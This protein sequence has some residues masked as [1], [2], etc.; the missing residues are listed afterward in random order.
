M[1]AQ[2]QVSSSS[3]ET[4]LADQ[5]DLK[6][7]SVRVDEVV[8]MDYRLDGRFHG[9]KGREAR[10]VLEECNWQ[11]VSFGDRF[12]KEAFYLG[13]L[14]RIYV[15]KDT[16]IPFLLPSQIT[17]LHPKA[18]KF[19]SQKTKIDFEAAKAKRGQ[20]LLT[21]SGTIGVVSY[22]SETLRNQ[23][24]SDDVIRIVAGCA[25]GYVYAYFK[26]EIGRTLIQ[27]NEYGAVVKHVEP[28]H[29]NDIPIPDPPWAL[30]K[31]IHDLIEDSF[32]LRDE[33]NALIDEAQHLLQAALELPDIESLKSG[34][35]KFETSAD[36]WN[37]STPVSQLNDRIDG[38]YHTPIVQ[39]IHEHLLKHAREVTSVG[40]NVIVK[41][42]VL[43]GRFK[44]HYVDEE[45][46]AVFFGGKQLY[47]LDPENKK[48]LSRKVH[49][50]LIRQELRI[51]TNTILIT[52]S[53]T[54]GKVAIVPEHW[55][56][57]VPNQHVMRVVPASDR[58]AGYL[59]AWLSSDFAFP[60]I[61]RQ[62]YAA[63]IDEIDASH[64]ASICVPLLHDTLVQQRINEMVLEA[65]GKRTRAYQL[66]QKA[67]KTLDDEVIY[68]RLQD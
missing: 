2:L 5:P 19:I 25:P 43:P 64:V 47:Q 23:T 50:E 37:F 4:R 46:G 65:N 44:R 58:I 14:K 61:T 33:S 31:K 55:S 27:T 62:A 35:P 7:V 60:L 48:Y 10:R 29:L 26:S 30:K 52:C 54:I 1:V 32:R 36:F 39:T 11:T 38:S 18:T 59:Y 16:G 68:S 24:I 22:V 57:W 12:L 51:H 41:S 17:D 40:D 63:V 49:D 34:A 21:R 67:L 9:S 53:G 28:H 8:A 15:G 6:W 13:R 20:V 3:N 45:N 42:I 56:S 66:E